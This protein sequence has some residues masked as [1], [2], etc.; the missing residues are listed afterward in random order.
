MSPF[1]AA[2]TPKPQN[3]INSIPLLMLTGLSL[4]TGAALSGNVTGRSLP[5]RPGALIFQN[6]LRM[7]Q[8]APEVPRIRSEIPRPT[9]SNR[10]RRRSL[11]KPGPSNPAK[12]ATQLFDKNMKPKSKR[13]RRPFTKPD[14]QRAHN[15]RAAGAC[16][17][18]HKTHRKVSYPFIRF[19]RG[20]ALIREVHSP[21]PFAV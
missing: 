20:N 3:I 4:S 14:K 16:V 21:S 18:C 17:K 10:P 6:P 13:K 1:G 9:A 7:V 15:V 5:V 12:E 8:S 19:D 2:L 11:V